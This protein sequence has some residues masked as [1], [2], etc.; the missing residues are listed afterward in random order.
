MSIRAG[1]YAP[2]KGYQPWCT[3]VDENGEL[4]WTT[5]MKEP[6]HLKMFPVIYTGDF[7]TQWMWKSLQEKG[8]EWDGE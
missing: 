4:V 2:E 7:M 6:W 8:L 3:G 1:V 5:K